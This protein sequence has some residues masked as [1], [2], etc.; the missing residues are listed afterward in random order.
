MAKPKRFL[1]R[2]VVVLAILVIVAVAAIPLVPLSPF[3]P[4]VELRLT[5]AL[6]RKVTC[7]SLHLSLITGPRFTITGMTALEDPAFGGGVF[8]KADRVL[9]DLDIVEYF[10]TRRIAIKAISIRSAQ[11][12]LV[13]NEDGAWNWATLSRE[14]N[15]LA[16]V[17]G[18]A[19]SF[20]SRADL[21]VLPL[22]LVADL[23]SASLRQIRVENA[24]VKLTYSSAPAVSETIW[25]N[26]KL[27]ASL[28]PATEGERGTRAIGRLSA[29]S[30]EDGE[31]ELFRAALPFDLKI[32]RSKDVTLLAAGSI[33]PGPLET[34]NLSVGSFSMN[35]QFSAEQ[36]GPLSGAGRL[37]V[38][39]ML[40]RSIN[41]SEHVAAA[42]RVSQIGDMS[43]GTPIGALEGEF[44]VSQGV[45]ETTG[46]QIREIDGLGDA[47]AKR[48]NFKID[49]GLMVNYRT[50][51]T[52]S[53]DATS[54]VKSAS[55]LLGVI[56]TILEIN[57]R[58]SVPVNINGDVRKP[59]IYVDVSRLF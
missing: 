19:A 15:G 9:A 34:K 54:R 32:G 1:L 8:L 48:G 2:L 25:K 43:P 58:L 5:E 40:I 35:G 38:G 49:S 27:D 33:G 11:I 41:L 59:Q 20:L 16:A 47:I 31:A 44:R 53:A 36:A 55:T 13:R 56:A 46:L 23:S 29:Q 3:K 22:L 26:V 18:Q 45:V 6:G 51:I 12:H 10:R 7:D 28:A 30:E 21:P 37:S 17:S 42:L 24:D 39:E 52:L 4:A 57:N 50:T 14:S